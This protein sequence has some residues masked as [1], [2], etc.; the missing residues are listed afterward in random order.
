MQFKARQVVCACVFLLV[1]GCA[2]VEPPPVVTLDDA[3]V[4]AQQRE[5]ERRLD[6]LASWAFVGKVRVSGNERPINADIRWIERGQSSEITLSGPGGFSA[7]TLSVSPGRVVLK[8]A[9]GDVISAATPDEL[10]AKLVGWPMPLSLMN[11]WV[12][13]LPGPAAVLSRDAQAQLESAQFRKWS[14]SFSRYK[15]VDGLALPH[16]IDVTDGHLSVSVQPKRWTLELAPPAAV[17]R[18][19][20]P[21]RAG[22]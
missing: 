13:G 5:R 10:I 8:R 9:N 6:E 17:D 7:S 11:D 22:A 4:R 20:I 12:L 18:I 14:G 3:A 21:G 2:T 16:R 1:S 19:P 15:Q